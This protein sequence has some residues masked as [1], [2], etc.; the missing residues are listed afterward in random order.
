MNYHAPVH[1]WDIVVLDA[2]MTQVWRTSMETRVVVTAW[3]FR[4]GE[5]RLI[6][7]AYLVAVAMQAQGEAKGQAKLPPNRVA[8]LLPITPEDHWLRHSAERRRAFRREE[9]HLAQWLAIDNSQGDVFAEVAAYMTPADGNGLGDAVF[10]GVILAT[11]HN[12]AC[13]A[14]ATFMLGQTTILVRQDRTD[15]LAPA[16]L[17]DTLQCR[18]ALT[19]TW[20][21]SAEVQVD[22][23]ALSPNSP[24]RIV[25]TTYMVFVGLNTLSEPSPVPTWQPVTQLQHQ[26]SQAAQVRRTCRQTEDNFY[27]AT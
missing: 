19:H 25:A 12:A 18:A 3:S 26:R 6:A 27:S 23:V 21:T 14:M 15:F 17:G 4:T 16:R 24:P 1:A 20:H 8:P 11:M 2:R 22:C 9:S 13:K 7:T 10:G 5:H